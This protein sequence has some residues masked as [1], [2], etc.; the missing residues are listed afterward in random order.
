MDT[1]LFTD[2]GIVLF[3][4]TTTTI[5]LMLSVLGFSTTDQTR[6]DIKRQFKEAAV[7]RGSA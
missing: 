3:C 2:Q 4:I 6:S 7:R 5:A 1:V